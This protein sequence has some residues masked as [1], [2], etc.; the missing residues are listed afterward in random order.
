MQTGLVLQV[1]GSSIRPWWIHHHYYALATCLLILTLPVDS[2]AYQAYL[3][4]FLWWSCYQVGAC[5]LKIE[6]C[7]LVWVLRLAHLQV[8]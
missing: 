7:L 2:D 5:L 6:L 1:N 8:A 3:K 4:P